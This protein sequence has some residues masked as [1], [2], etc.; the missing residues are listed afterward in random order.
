MTMQKYTRQARPADLS[1]IMPIIH[2]AKDQLKATG[3]SQWQGTYPAQSDIA[4]DIKQ[5][6]GFVFVNGKDIA[7]YA[8]VIVGD[9]PTYQK[10]DGAWENEQDPYATIHRICFSSAYQ[11]A[12]LAKVFMSDLLS[13]QIAQGVV[14]FRID[15]SKYNLPMQAVAKHN[16]FVYRGIIQ[17]TADQENPDRLAY[18]LNID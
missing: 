6:Y 5:G 8:A 14:N 16:G 2:D 9:E 7:G 13:L 3:S 17:V 12:G 10:I 18:E 4:E 1:Q 15:T 11:G